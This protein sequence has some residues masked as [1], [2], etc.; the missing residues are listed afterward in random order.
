LD[1][2]NLIVR[3][4][5]ALKELSGT[6]LGVSIGIH[7]QIPMESGLGGGS[8]NAAATLRALNQ[9]WELELPESELHTIA[10]RLGSDINFLLSGCRAA[11]CRG[12]GERI[13]AVQMSGQMHGVL[14]V[15][16][17]GNSTREVFAAL[18]HTEDVKDPVELVD[19][20]GRGDFRCAT[21]YSFNRLQ[22]PACDIN[23][24][25]RQ[26]L[27]ELKSVTGAGILTGSGSAC[28]S[29]VPTEKQAQLAAAKLATL[30][31]SMISTFRC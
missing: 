3:A 24:G 27:K 2:T 6:P 17:T 19:A 29:I 22:V 8:G 23:P 16:T 11:I 7:K 18:Q 13:E 31:P 9:L 4:A 1:G 30:S 26:V 14:A 25:M 12:R 15:P 5:V 28:F 21:R 20:L 10:A